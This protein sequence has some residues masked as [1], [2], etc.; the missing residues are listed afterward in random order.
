MCTIPYQIELLEDD[1]DEELDEEN[2]HDYDEYSEHK[3]HI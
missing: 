3:K 1:I 2:P